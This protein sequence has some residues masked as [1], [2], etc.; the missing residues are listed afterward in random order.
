MPLER[1]E[2]LFNTWSDRYIQ[3]LNR[4]DIGYVM[5]FENRGEECGVT[6][7]HPHGQIYCYPFIPPVI[8]KEIEAFNKNNFIL[9]MMENLEKTKKPKKKRFDLRLSDLQN[10]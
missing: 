6:L 10:L 5:P 1:I 8:E 7:H 4:D 2:L 3:L 9:S